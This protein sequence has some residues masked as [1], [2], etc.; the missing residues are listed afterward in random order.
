M[1]NNTG[2]RT[3]QTFRHRSFALSLLAFTTLI[4]AGFILEG[5]SLASLEDRNT[6]PVASV[7][8]KHRES[9]EI[10]IDTETLSYEDLKANLDLAETYKKTLTAELNGYN[11]QLSAYGNILLLPQT[12]VSDLEKAE[13]R[14][15]ECP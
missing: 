11:V 7:T 4:A 3:S 12:S 6:N 13:N 8:E 15:P 14:H 10:T 9:I 1:Q 5:N 2:S